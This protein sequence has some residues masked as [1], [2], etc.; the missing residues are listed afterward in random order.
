MVFS[1]HDGAHWQAPIR[2][3]AVR[4]NQ[5]L[6]GISHIKVKSAKRKEGEG[7]SCQANQRGDANKKETVK[8]SPWC[9]LQLSLKG[10]S[11]NNRQA[12]NSKLCVCQNATLYV[13]PTHP[14]YC[15]NEVA[16]SFT[17]SAQQRRTNNIPPVVHVGEDKKSKRYPRRGRN[18]M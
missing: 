13:K 11:N 17:L 18:V 9:Q 10:Q 2:Y 14:L 16:S 1:V 8:N 4:A 6:P 15:T 12:C 5:K 7:R 3:S